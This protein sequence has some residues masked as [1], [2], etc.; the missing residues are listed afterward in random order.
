MPSAVGHAFH[1]SAHSLVELR[2]GL[3]NVLLAIC[4]KKFFNFLTGGL[5][6]S[7]MRFMSSVTSVSNGGAGCL[8][9]G[10]GRSCWG[11][12]GNTELASCLHTGQKNSPCSTFKF[13]GRNGAYNDFKYASWHVR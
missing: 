1:S 4:H 10:V 6:F 2:C 13:C 5:L 9:I 11:L 8:I 7:L 3:K 12:R